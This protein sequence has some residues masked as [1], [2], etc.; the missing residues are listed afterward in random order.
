[1]KKHSIGLT[2]AAISLSLSAVCTAATTPEGTLKEF[3]AA[4]HKKD[5]KVLKASIDWDA[6]GKAM[7]IDKEKDAERRR[8]MKDLLQTTFISAFSGMGKQAEG[9]QLG[10]VTQKGNEAKGHFMRVDPTTRKMTPS[11]EFTLAK[12]G[13]NWYI[14]NITQPLRPA[15]TTDSKTDS[16]R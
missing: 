7:Q 10:K 2:L 6:M 12:K 9:I 11:T 3:L 8:M 5:K 14:V 1:L 4:M 15:S 13:K 16:K